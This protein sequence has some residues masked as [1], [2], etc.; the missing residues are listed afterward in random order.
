MKL[1]Y[2]SLLRP[3]CPSLSSVLLKQRRK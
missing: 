1:F 2:I 3:F